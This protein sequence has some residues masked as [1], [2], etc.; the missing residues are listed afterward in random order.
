VCKLGFF[1]MVGPQL[2]SCYIYQNPPTQEK[3][4]LKQT[5]NSMYPNSLQ[6]HISFM[7]Y[8]WLWER[9]IKAMF[10]YVIWSKTNKKLLLVNAGNNK[11]NNCK[12]DYSRSELLCHLLVKDK[13][14]GLILISIYFIRTTYLTT[15]PF[16]WRTRKQT[17]SKTK[18][19]QNKQKRII[20]QLNPCD[21]NWINDLLSN[22]IY[23]YFI[24]T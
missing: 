13:P 3:I 21:F 12:P 17:I 10:P 7:L 11:E 2:K 8:P 19:Q 5:K 1:G 15:T 14:R 22:C 24:H 9:K 4:I 20:T 16:S 6:I 18:Q 23:I